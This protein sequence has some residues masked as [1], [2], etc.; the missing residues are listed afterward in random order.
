M[1]VDFETQRV[2]RRFVS[3]SSKSSPDGGVLKKMGSAVV[4]FQLNFF[5]KLSKKFFFK[6]IFIKTY[7]A[8]HERI[9]SCLE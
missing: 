6:R 4:M 8:D 2:N 7:L 3:S 9:D 5:W 1:V